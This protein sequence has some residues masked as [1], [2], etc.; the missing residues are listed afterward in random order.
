MNESLKTALKLLALLLVGSV[1]GFG[2]TVI[3]V[4]QKAQ[5][6]Q[7]AFAAEEYSVGARYLLEL[8]ETNP[9]WIS[10]W[11]SAGQAA[12]LAGD[13]SLALDAYLGAYQ[14]E[15]LSEAGQI[16][17][18]TTYLYLG[19][20]QEAERI[21]LELSDSPSAM[22]ELADLYEEEG[23]IS[24]AIE[25]WSHY[26]ALL[27]ET[28]DPGQLFYFGLLI[29]ADS[30]PKAL[31]YL[32]QSSAEYPEAGKAAERI[33][34]AIQE[35]PAYQLL[36]AGQALASANRW[37]LASFAFEKAVALR[38]DYP[39]AW[40]YWGES[41][42]HIENPEYDPLEILQNGLSLDEDSPLGNLFLGLY[43]QRAGSHATALDFFAVVENLWPDRA[44]VLVEEGKS[45]AVLGELEAAYLKYQEAIEL[46][47]Q[48]P[49]YYRM[50]AEFCLSYAFQI[51]EA[52]LPAGRLAVQFG[53]QDPA[54]VD[55]LGQVL[56]ALED[57]KNALRL[58]QQ[59]LALDPEYAPAYYQLG[60]LFSARDDSDPAVYYLSQAVAYSEN[61]ALTDQAQRLLLS[62]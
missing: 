31:V 28:P 17:L 26:L 10:L 6:V 54:N 37:R 59:A 1:I 33:R 4:T 61:P 62:Y 16:N 24:R 30:P 22:K 8:A 41:L 20:P 51:R 46:F 45:L 25:F 56:L 5:K 50:L 7:T 58:F 40:F 38:P 39:E 29:A 11:E 35:E 32:D 15:D 55:V 9:W 12:F 23:D 47:P 49:G 36:S 18:G 3:S 2:P 43:W 60:I 44:D 13:Y 53:P 42:Q 34:D 27:E 57:E 19:D 14:R 48:D 52:G 21:W